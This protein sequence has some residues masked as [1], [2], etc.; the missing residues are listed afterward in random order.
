MRGAQALVLVAA[1]SSATAAQTPSID[2]A[3]A[4]ARALR[5]EG[6]LTAAYGILLNA[7]L[8]GHANHETQL[9]LAVIE[10]ERDH[11]EAAAR[12]LQ[13]ALELAPEGIERDLAEALLARL[14]PETEPSPTTP[15]HHAEV[16]EW[17]VYR[18]NFG[19]T[20]MR[21][22]IT[23]V[24]EA[25]VTFVVVST[26]APADGSIPSFPEPTGQPTV[27]ELAEEQSLYRDPRELDAIIEVREETVEVGGRSLTVTVVRREHGGASSELWYNEAEIP[28][29][30][31]S[32]YRA[33]RDDTLYYELLDFGTAE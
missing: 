5:A 4:E 29:F 31:Q 16:G 23:A 20:L 7:T 26:Q 6:D 12:H 21:F 33:L 1:L 14:Q 25:T 28:P 13:D 19:N 9:L 11:P 27:V 8:F 24:D 3:H 22:E 17:A 15:W 30:V 2:E 10:L 32:C 18:S